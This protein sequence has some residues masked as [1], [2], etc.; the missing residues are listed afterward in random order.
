VH[1]LSVADV[2]RPTPVTVLNLPLAEYS[3]GHELLLLRRRNALALLSPE[4]FSKLDFALQIHAVREAV[5]ICSD[6]FSV[7]DR[8]EQP[9]RFMWGF[10][11]NEW[12]RRRWVNRQ[13][14]LL[15][16]DYALAAVDFRNYLEAAHPQIPTPGKHA[17]D[18]L[19]P[20]DEKSGR[21]FGQPMILS[22]YQMVIDMPESE[23]PVCA[24]DFPYARATWIF[25]AQ[26]ETAGSFRI[27]NFEERDEQSVMDG[28]RSDVKRRAE[29]GG[30]HGP[31][32]TASGLATAP[33][34][35]SDSQPSTAN[36]QPGEGGAQ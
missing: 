33:P 35:L 6:P 23:R 11:W 26:L 12:K 13:R 4:E 36:S 31:H 14:H 2:F 30:G 9:A 25:F 3:I 34:D 16:H 17:C 18:V 1:E 5:W 28:A 27:E 19:Y 24:W 22:F 15:P 32:A 20:E 8:F 29:D 10:R 7:R 21:R